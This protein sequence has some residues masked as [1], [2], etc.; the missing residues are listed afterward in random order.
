MV[1]AKICISFGSG[2]LLA[3]FSEILER[4]T[5]H[6]QARAVI[7]LCKCLMDTLCNSENHTSFPTGSCGEDAA[8]LLATL[9]DVRRRAIAV[10]YRL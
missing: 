6:S 4:A 1:V 10:D 7:T 9:L 2:K 5:S 8:E 3:V